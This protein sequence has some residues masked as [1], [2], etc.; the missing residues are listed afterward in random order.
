[1]QD[2][3]YCKKAGT[4]KASLSFNS[5]RETIIPDAV[6][7]KYLEVSVDHTLSQ[8]TNPRWAGTSIPLYNIQQ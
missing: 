8:V 4:K 5:Y 6:I 7:L 2:A 1:M 3:Y